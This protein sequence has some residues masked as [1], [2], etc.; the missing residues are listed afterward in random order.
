MEVI[1]GKLLGDSNDDANRL[2]QKIE[3][4]SRDLEGIKRYLERLEQRQQQLEMV[5]EIKQQQQIQAYRAEL[6]SIQL[7]V[8]QIAGKLTFLEKTQLNKIE[9]NLNSLEQQIPKKMFWLGF[10]SSLI[11]G[12]IS[13]WNWFELH[14]LEN[15]TQSQKYSLQ[16]EM[17]WESLHHNFSNLST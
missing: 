14:P 3:H 2:E 9:S 5:V 4:F 11:L 7:P 12:F 13:L 8:K 6:K 1:N 15:Q 17:I 16:T 10:Y